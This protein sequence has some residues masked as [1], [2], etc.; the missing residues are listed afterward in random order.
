MH[1]R[2]LPFRSLPHQPKLLLDFLDGHSRVSR[3]YPLP[4]SLESAIHAAKTLNYPQDRR[5]SISKILRE[6]NASFGAGSE[7]E[8][9]LARF[10]N[11][12]IAIV[13]GQQVGLFTGPAY[14]IYKAL[15]A[16]SIAKELTE[17]GAEAVPI[18]WM[19]TEDHDLDEV[20]HTTFFHN[21]E[22]ARFELPPVSNL[23]ASVGAIRLGES[24]SELASAASVMLTGEEGA[25]LARLLREAYVPEATYG[26][27]FA[28]VFARLFAAQGLILLDPLD[29]G[30]HRLASTV[31][32]RAIE[33]RES[34]HAELLHRGK[35]LEREGYSTQVKV[36]SRSSLLFFT[37]GGIRQAINVSDKKFR[38]GEMAWS[39]DELLTRI[40]VEPE[41]FSANA[42]LRP[43]VQDFLFP[44][45][46]CVVGPSEISYYAQS[47]VLY[48]GILG[49]MPALVPR[50][51][52]TLVD[53]KGQRLLEEYGLQVEDVWSGPQ[54]LCRRLQ[55]ANLPRP[56]AKQFE[57][58]TKQISKVLEKWKE[59]LAKVDP[60]LQPAVETSGRKI[61][62][63]V[64]K[65]R[66]K[67]GKAF[68]RK[69]GILASHEDFLSHL[70]YPN[71]ALQ[72]RDLN[73]LPFLARFGSSGLK[74]LGDCISFKSMGKHFIV[75]VP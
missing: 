63:Q 16:I 59:A 26:R 5:Q 12:A 50:A 48:R 61:A 67:A 66:Q 30:V 9:N 58:D 15:S 35:E 28:K 1:C 21:G 2:A 54:S 38:S 41:K 73:L 23:G 6:Q 25:I 49:R 55:S 51:D 3:F 36:T 42:L 13:T 17:A 57:K 24:V 22:L 40:R 60:T 71:K 47:E 64:D 44:T 70:M 74:D 34:L 52:F 43:V 37:G 68:D 14:S 46:A 31:Y 18:F 75:P 11:G 8:R 20:R 69:S 10:E 29:P 4:P 32:A 39:R 45:A 19:A 33:G 56:L 65:L 7:T 27:A 53:P 62:F 72:S